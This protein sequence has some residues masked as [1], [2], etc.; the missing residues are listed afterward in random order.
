ML[1]H[2]PPAEVSLRELSRQVGLS[3][4]NVVRYFPTREADFLAVLTGR[5]GRHGSTAVESRA[6]QPGRAP[7][8]T[9]LLPAGR[10]CHC[11]DTE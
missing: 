8:A 4:S 2:L 9:G 6:A 10:G 5:L 1:D 11:P 3:K 7:T